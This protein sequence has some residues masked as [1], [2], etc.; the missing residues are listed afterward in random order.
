M[1]MHN[2]NSHSTFKVLIMCL[3]NSAHTPVAN[4]CIETVMRNYP[5]NKVRHNLLHPARIFR[6]PNKNLSTSLEPTQ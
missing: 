4:K 2:L 5:T 6:S 3:I 1:L